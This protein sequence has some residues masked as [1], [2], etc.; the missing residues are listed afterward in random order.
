MAGKNSPD[1]EKPTRGQLD[2][3]AL[4]GL[5]RGVDITKPKPWLEKTSFEVRKVHNEHIIVTKDGGLLQAY[6]EEIRSRASLH[7]EVKAGLKPPNL[8]IKIGV[9][10]EYT[11]TTLSSKHIVGTKVKNRT[12]SFRVDFVDVPQPLPKPT[13]AEATD[14]G[15]VTE[16]GKPQLQTMKQLS[17]EKDETF[18]ERLRNWLTHRLV[19][20]G[21]K[22]TLNLQELICEDDKYGI[23]EDV[24]HFV[25]HF[26]VTHYVSSIELGALEYSVL[27]QKEYHQKA[28]M[29]A[30]ASL[31]ALVHGGLQTS[32]KVTKTSILTKKVSEEKKIGKITHDDESKCKVVRRK[33]EAVIGC[34]V[35]PI[36]TLV[37]NPYL[38]EIVAT[39]VKEY[40]KSKA[41]GMFL[42]TVY[43]I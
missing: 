36:I 33:D 12:V 40:I 15:D 29:G 28:K 7:S 5:G 26:G 31:D 13:A 24:K 11:R 3:Y 37:K 6:N 42:S 19:D 18:E 34:E 2:D 23:K 14:T 17:M 35:V 43:V 21:Y 10:A 20:R 25:Q 38:Q 22:S 39:S 8:P 4:W 9:D 32:A 41:I 16:S 30:N 27:T 1:P